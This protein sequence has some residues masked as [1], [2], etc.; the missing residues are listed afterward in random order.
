MDLIRLKLPRLAPFYNITLAVNRKIWTDF[1]YV[2]F[3]LEGSTS[4]HLESIERTSFQ[5]ASL[6]RWLN[7]P[8]SKV[9]KSSVGMG[10]GLSYAL[11]PPMVEIQE[12]PKTAN[13]LT[14]LLF[15]YAFDLDSLSIWQA[16]FRVHHRSGAY[17]LFNGVVGGSDYICLGARYSF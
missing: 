2:A 3:E 7:P 8:S 14:H 12:L 9:V 15:E 16:F 5:V 6:F 11:S 13:L 1:K 17:G 4:F 10:I